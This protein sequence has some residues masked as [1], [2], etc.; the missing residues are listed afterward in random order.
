MKTYQ[1]IIA[2]L[3]S[4]LSFSIQAQ[5][6]AVSIPTQTTT[7]INNHYISVSPFNAMRGEFKGSYELQVPQTRHSFVLS[8]SLIQKGSN[9]RSN[10]FKVHK[11]QGYIGEFQY[12]YQFNNPNGSRNKLFVGA[13]SRLTKISQE[14]TAID[15]DL[16]MTL[17][18]FVP[19]FSINEASANGSRS[20][21]AIDL[22]GVIGKQWML[23]EHLKIE[24]LTG[25][26]RNI[27]TIERSK[28][29]EVAGYHK[30]W[31]R[32]YKFGRTITPRFNCS[33]GFAF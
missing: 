12:R 33:I 16:D 11:E 9:E 19:I 4:L 25:L 10:S 2:A 26:G 24:L 5:N 20:Y 29:A 32:T 30:E 1:I 3:F 21:Q 22:G 27:Q 7:T 23:G 31:A 6:E 13:Y 8:G 18:W 15:R 17:I 28:G 14:Y